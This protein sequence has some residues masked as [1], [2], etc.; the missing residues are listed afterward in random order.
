MKRIIH[1]DRP[2]PRP[3]GGKTPPTRVEPSG[4]VYDRSTVKGRTRT[5]YEGYLSEEVPELS[6][7]MEE[8]RFC[9]KCGGHLVL[10]TLSDAERK[11]CEDCGHVFYINPTPAAGAV[12]SDG[13][14]VLWVR[15]AFD[16]KQGM[17][18]LPAGFVEYGESAEACA[19]REVK[20][21]TDLDISEL[22]LVGVYAGGDD[23]RTRVI[24]VIYAPR[25]WSGLPRPGDDATEIGWFD[26]D[27]SPS[28]VAF[29]SHI[30]AVRDAR[31]LLKR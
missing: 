7:H 21:E 31:A 18:C 15:R 28:E 6:S 1:I 12:I 20:E 13:G 2:R 16:P 11:V 26:R 9:P 8:I 10:R 4:K 19:I 14:K 5:A 22:Q 17:W 3:R 29:R 23:P 27:R 25:T 24:L 30:Q